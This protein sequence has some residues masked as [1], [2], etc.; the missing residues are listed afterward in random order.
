MRRLTGIVVLACAFLMLG[1]PALAHAVLVSSDPAGGAQIARAP[2]S[3]TLTFDENVESGLGSLRVLDAAGTLRSSG[4]VTHPG[5]DGRRVSVHAGALENGRYVVAWQVVSAD[6]HLVDGAFAFG[7]GVPAGDAP[8]LPADNG[9]QLLLPILHFALL[10]GVLLGI[11]LPIGVAFIARRTRRKPTPVEFGAWFVVAFAAFG[12]VAFRADL[13]GGS[14]TSAFVT[15]I[16]TLRGI[17]LASAAVAIASL[18]GTQRRWPTLAIACIAAALSL[19]L[20]GHG[21]DGALPIAGVTVDVLHLIGA[22]TWIGILAIGSTLE[23]GPELRGISPVAMTAVIVLIVTGVVQTLRNVGS[24]AALFGSTYGRLVDAKIALLIVLLAFAYGA[25]RALARGTF[26]IAA[27][28]KL[29]LWLLTA[30]VA[31]TAVL[32]ESPLPR[33][34]AP[35]AAAS[36]TFTLRDIAVHATAVSSGTMTWIVHVDASGPIDGTDVTVRERHRN[37]GP[38]PVTMN[39]SDAGSFSGTVTLPFAGA[40]TAEI[41]VRSGPFDEA[42]HTLDMPEQSP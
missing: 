35:L 9:A 42:H 16:G 36:A 19:S 28:I 38:L 25:R 4:A 12:D 27:R 29:E 41:S 14:L 39:R 32:V 34:A 17:T 3:V 11:G 10:G 40:W 30:V 5:G 7:V 15:H 18:V 26:A 6:S 37:V 22:A 24:F 21:G 20:A 13:A 31:I 8:V 23:A 2:Q 33:E 1:T